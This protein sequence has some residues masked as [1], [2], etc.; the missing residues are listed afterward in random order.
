MKTSFQLYPEHLT[1]ESPFRSADSGAEVIFEG[2]VRSPNKGK[3]VLYLEF[4]AYEA[5]FG[6]EMIR[7]ATALHEKFDLHALMLHH[8][9]GKVYPGECAVLAAVYA[10]HRD[11]AFM[12][13]A[14][15]MNELKKSAP[16][17]KKEFH[18]DGSFW[19]SATP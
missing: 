3:Q 1:F 19:V 18:E 4:E 11:H 8:R 9:I 6:N 15:L 7:I 16:I 13:C 5:L 17:W 10:K 14:E 2:I 12:A